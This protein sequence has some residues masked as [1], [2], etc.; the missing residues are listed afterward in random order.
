MTCD[1]RHL[2]NNIFFSFFFLSDLF[3]LFWFVL[4]LV[5]ISAY[6]ERFIVIVCGIFVVSH[7]SCYYHYLFIKLDGVALHWLASTLFP[8]CDIQHTRDGEHSLKILG[9]GSLALT[10]W[11]GRSLK[12]FLQR[13]TDSVSQLM[14]DGGV[15][16]KAPATPGQLNRFAFSEK[17]HTMKN[18]LNH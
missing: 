4:V 16:R 8:L 1:T 12:I 14:N 17:Q 2:T 13:M 5:L 10:V 3:C 6:F 9:P 15:C 11:E 7:T 18:G